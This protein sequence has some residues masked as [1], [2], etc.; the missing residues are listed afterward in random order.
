MEDDFFTLAKDSISIILIIPL[1]QLPLIIYGGDA[2]LY[3]VASPLALL[4]L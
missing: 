2:L 4:L 3:I 1:S